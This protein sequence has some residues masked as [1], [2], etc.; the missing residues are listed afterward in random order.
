MINYIIN[1]L[2]QNEILKDYNKWFNYKDEL[3]FGLIIHDFR[4]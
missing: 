2:N 1:F 4:R 3:K